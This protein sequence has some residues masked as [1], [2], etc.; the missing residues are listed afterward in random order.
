MYSEDVGNESNLLHVDTFYV[1]RSPRQLRRLSGLATLLGLAIGFLVG[2]AEPKSPSDL[3]NEAISKH[4]LHGSVNPIEAGYAEAIQLFDV[5]DKSGIHFVH[6]DGSFGKFCLPETMSGGLALFDYDGDA[7]IDIYFCNGAPLDPGVTVPGKGN[8]LYKNLGGL[9]FKDVTAESG[10]TCTEFGL[11]VTVGDYDNDGFADIYA[12]NFGVN[13]LYHNN[14][15]GGFQQVPMQIE[16]EGDEERF[17]AGASFADFD[18]DGNLDLFVGNYVQLSP[19]EILRQMQLARTQYPGPQDFPPQT[20]LLWSNAGDGTWINLSA[21][22]N[23]AKVRGTGMG[24][25]TGDFDDDGDIDIYVANDELPNFLFRNN[26]KGVFEESAF[27]L[28]IAVDA[29][30]VASGSMGVDASDLN[31]DGRFDLVVTTFEN[32]LLTLYQMTEHA[33]F[34]DVTRRTHVGDGTQPHVTWGCCIAD[35]ENDGDR[36]LFV[37]SGHLDQR[38]GDRYY[39]V[40]DLLI[41]NLL[42]ESNQFEFAN[43]AQQCGDMGSTRHCSRGAAAADLDNDGDLD[44]VVLNLREKPTLFENRSLQSN[45]Q[46]LQMRLVGTSANR[47]AN[48]TRVRIFASKLLLVDEVRNGRGYQSY[49]GSRLHF[50][51]GTEPRIERIEIDWFNGRTQ[52]IENVTANQVLTMV[53]PK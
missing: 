39:H 10:L 38:S 9:R 49:W 14:G 1:T 2:C 18:S 50:G 52:V 45:N 46:W 25:V 6:D 26:G 24:C 32:E 20:N 41:K 34:Q 35:F 48:G 53:Q 4:K 16:E 17:S 51:L 7:L 27:S 33:I 36:D 15:D 37:A 42:R 13:T 11:G 30:G 12:S 29:V 31:N 21:T 28:G 40:H 19:K 22:S 5:T 8:A 3:Q 47:D 23:I 43:I 44:M